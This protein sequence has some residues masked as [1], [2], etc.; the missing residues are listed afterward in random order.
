MRRMSADDLARLR[1]L[2]EAGERRVVAQKE[3]VEQLKASGDK[4]SAAEEIILRSM[5]DGL[6]HV[7]RQ[8]RDA[9]ERA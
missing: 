5:R 1:R 8:L 2:V 7:R 9:G 6:S 4:A 3:L